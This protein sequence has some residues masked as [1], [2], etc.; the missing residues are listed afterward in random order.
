MQPLRDNR[1][2]LVASA[3]GTA[4]EY[5]DFFIYATAAALVFGPLFFPAKDPATQTMLAFL[6]F[7]VAFIARPV[8]AVVFGHFGD[9]IGRKSTLVASLL[10]MGVS[11]LGIAVLPTH[12][13]TAAWGVG[14]LAPALLCLMRF[15]QGMGLGGE[16]AGAA[17]LAIENAPPGWK[18]RFGCVPQLGV[19]IG[20]M[21]AN[22]AFLALDAV[23]TPAQFA[24]WG[25]R[26]PFLASAVLVALGLWVR[27]KIEETLEFRHVLDHERVEMV[28]IAALGAHGRLVIA[29]SAG[30]ISTYALFYIASTF[31]LSAATGPL[32]Y[33]RPSFLA[34]QLVAN[35]FLAAGIAL[36]GWVA[37]RTSPGRALAAGA[38]ITMLSGLVFWPALATGSLAVAAVM[39]CVVNLGQGFNA[40]PLGSW[41]SPLLPARVRYTGVAFA[42]NIGGIVGGAVVPN[43]AQASLKA[44][45]SANVGPLLVACGVASLA[46]VLATRNA[47]AA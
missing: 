35:L 34:V 30:V 29:G 17:L 8:G 24:D 28:P 10:L 2:V 6:S 1:R 4:V 22:G 13:Q 47:K 44:G 45:A 42:F 27:L 32:H 39:L 37:D 38:V 23:L 19:P 43:L 41:L 12:A 14:W 16:W 11:T 9:R 7:G 18:A 36:A 46:G 40:G 26:I 21:A 3:M 5:Y 20:F 15:G 31:A 25:W 33:A